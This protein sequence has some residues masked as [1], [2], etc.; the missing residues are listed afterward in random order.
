MTA[1]KKGRPEFVATDE[2]RHKVRVLKA[3]GMSAEAIAEAINISEP[4]LRKYFSLDLEVGAA[5][6]TAEMLMARYNAGIGGNVNA[7]NKW[8][9]AAGAIPP[10]PRREPKPPA[11]G[12]KEILEEEAQVERASPGW[13]DVLQ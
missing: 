9:E 4:T 6:V 2:D 11:K 10:K 1:K 7:Q 3:G 8:L 13:G 12:K 5:K